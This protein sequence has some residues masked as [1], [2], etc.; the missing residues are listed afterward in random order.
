MVKC[1]PNDPAT[2]K[3]GDYSD[4]TKKDWGH[5][6][7]GHEKPPGQAEDQLQERIH[8]DGMM[9]G[10]TLMVQG[11]GRPKPRRG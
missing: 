3:S 9:G 11:T 1:R 6:A 5:G 10:R 7:N 8:P 2:E 4:D